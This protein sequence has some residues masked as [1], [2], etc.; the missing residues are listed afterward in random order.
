MA[1]WQLVAAH[2]IPLQLLISLLPK[3]KEDK[4]CEALA[5]LI[6]MIK[7]ERPNNDLLKSLLSCPIQSFVSSLLSH[8]SSESATSLAQV[9]ANQFNVALNM[10]A[11]P[12]SLSSNSN[13]PGK[14]K[15][16][17]MNS[18]SAATGFKAAPSPGSGID[19][20]IELMMT[21]MEALRT[22]LAAALLT[23]SEFARFFDTTT[24]IV[25]S[26]C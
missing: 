20:S 3:L 17:T 19:T 26:H 13:S 23:K 7:H 25:T 22:C 5:A 16:T 24:T 6:T 11:L 1:L 15:R 9:L 18:L 12:G 4:H 14:R 8:W 2:S 21:H 10:N